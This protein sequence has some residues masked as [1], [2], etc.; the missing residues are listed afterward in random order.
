MSADN[1][2]D[3]PAVCE[4]CLGPNPYLQMIRER[5]GLECKLC[6]RPFTVYKWAPVKNGPFK[7]T[8]ICLTCAKQRNC[9]QSCLL[10][11]TYGI[12]I[13]L[14]D[15]ALKMAGVDGVQ[16][17][18]EPKNE[19]SKLYVANNSER[20]K[21]IGG[22][23]VTSNRDKAKEIL[24]KLAAVK[25]NRPSK[26]ANAQKRD[27]LP[28]HIENIDVSKIVSKLPFNGSLEPPSNPELK[29]LFIF[30]VDD[31]LPEY[32]ITEFFEQ[33]GK[34]KSVNCQ[35][36]ARC[37]FVTFTRRVDAEAAAKSISCPISGQSGLFLIENIPLRVTWGKERSLG[38]T[39]REKLKVGSIVTKFLKK[40]SKN[41]MNTTK[42]TNEEQTN[43]NEVKRVK[44][45]TRKPAK[46]ADFEKTFK[47]YEY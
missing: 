31:S 44:S 8:I 6:T 7:H 11:L 32:K 19:V 1:K 15:A 36:G 42:R 21:S 43:N 2:D 13:Q 26:S 46:E 24:E 40:L 45:D 17:A 23:A 16:G 41:S 29:T 47:N 5:G 35:H 39:N 4:T 37:A 20:F 33:F 3:V 38:T 22:A 9:C 30:G 10:D 25:G 28:Q 18:S 34:L 14:R 12:P 27:T